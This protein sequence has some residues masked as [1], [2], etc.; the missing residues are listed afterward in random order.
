MTSTAAVLP[1]RRNREFRLV[2]L[3]D[4]VSSLGNGVSQLAYPLLMLAITGSP[5]AA[6]V[7]SVTRAVP[8]VVLGLPAGALVD[9]WNRRYVMIICDLVRAVNMLTIPAALIWGALAPAQLYVASFIGGTAYVFFNAAQGACLPHV[10]PE[11]QLTRAVSAQETAESVTGV[12]ASPI[13]GALLQLL[14]ALPFLLDAISFLVSAACF[15]AVRNDFRDQTAEDAGTEPA[16]RQSWRRDISAGVE[17]MWRNKTL[18]MIG[19]TAAGLQLAISGVSLVAIVI[20]RGGGASSGAIGI[21]FS[22]IGIGGAAGAAVAPKITTKL[23]TGGTIL[24]VLWVHAIVWVLLAF[25][26]HLVVIAVA[27]SLFTLT[28]PWFGIAAYSYLLN[29]TPDHLRGRVGTAFNLL[30]WIATP[31]SGAILG[32]LLEITAPRTVSLLVSGWIALIAIIVTASR[33]V[34]RLGDSPRLQDPE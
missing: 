11:K 3:A 28:M 9:R 27:L 14:R 24:L 8:Y 7:L 22:A 21:T 17:W 32:Y 20:A 12:V 19:L 4:T 30:L 10:V 16:S 34:R 1:L 23:H 29:V 31:L 18:R 26:T 5:L 13:G 2:W 15:I 6:G 33:P 25:T